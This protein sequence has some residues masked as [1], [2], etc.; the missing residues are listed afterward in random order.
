MWNNIDHCF[1][2]QLESQMGNLRDFI[3]GFR[4]VKTAPPIWQF[5]LTPLLSLLISPP[6]LYDCLIK[7][8]IYKVRCLFQDISP[9]ACTL[10]SCESGLLLLLCFWVIFLVYV[11]SST[12][13]FVIFQHQ[14]ALIL[15]PW[16]IMVIVMEMELLFSAVTY[17]STYVKKL[18]ITLKK[19]WP[20]MYL[21][22]YT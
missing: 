10:S 2:K 19:I 20:S 17:Y 13:D 1:A 3:Q 18:S 16:I 11:D 21:S 4:N 7:Y 12:Q 8:D 9:F 15:S 22:L 5:F 14:T 6:I